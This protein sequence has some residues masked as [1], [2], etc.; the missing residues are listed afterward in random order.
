[1]TSTS[2]SSDEESY[3]NEDFFST[4][5]EKINMKPVSSH[6]KSLDTTPGEIKKCW[7][8]KNP[9][10][11]RCQCTRYPVVSENISRDYLY[12]LRAYLKVVVDNAV[13]DNVKTTDRYW[14]VRPMLSMIRKVCLQHPCP[15]MGGQRP[16]NSEMTPMHEKLD[17]GGKVV[18]KLSDTLPAGT[19]IFMNRIGLAKDRLLKREGRGSFEHRVRGDDAIAIVKWHDNLAIHLAST[20]CG[21]N[22]VETYRRWSIRQCR[23]IEIPHP[24]AVKMYNSHTGGVDLM[25]MVISKYAMRGRMKKW[26]IRNAAIEEKCTNSPDRYEEESDEEESEERE[27]DNEKKRRLVQPIPPMAKRYKCDL[28]MPKMSTEKKNSSRCRGT[29]CS[30]LMNAR[31]F[32][33]MVL[34]PFTSHEEECMSC[35]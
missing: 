35:K 18:L 7:A 15:K 32:E 10:S 19:M 5:A 14:K 1:M 6:E 26:T 3:L 2:S 4:M 33:C 25:D 22:P 34:L 13:S 9:I 28:H 8:A 23:Y 21:V 17:I 12:C 24:F 29:G 30:K 16:V 11:T 20:Y 31:C 27:E